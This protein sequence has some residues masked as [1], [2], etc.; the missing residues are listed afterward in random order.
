MILLG[1]FLYP[2]QLKRAYNRGLSVSFQG[3]L[4]HQNCTFF[5]ISQE[6]GAASNK[7]ILFETH[8]YISNQVAHTIL[9]KSDSVCIQSSVRK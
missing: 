6:K 3:A 7:S 4:T 2:E 8:Q 1:C 9:I 5:M